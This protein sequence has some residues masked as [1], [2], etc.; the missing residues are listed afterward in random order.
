MP[1]HPWKEAPI[2][3]PAV[4]VAASCTAAFAVAPAAAELVQVD[5]TGSVEFSQVTFG[6]FAGVQ[7]GDA[8]SVAF[9]LDSNTF[10]DSPTLPTRGTTSTRRRSSSTSG[11]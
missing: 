4:A 6:A 9:L 3:A 5:I 11:A 2:R 7:A 1:H 8:V 10:L